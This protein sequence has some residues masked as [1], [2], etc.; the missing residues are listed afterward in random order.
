MRILILTQKVDKDD[1]T[2]GF[3]YR[4]IVEFSKDA[5]KVS[6]VCLEEGNHALPSNVS[7]YSLGKN[8]H[9]SRLSY[10]LN[11]YKYIWGLRNEYD[12]VFVHMNPEY[13]VM[14]GLIW[15]V[16]GK[17]VS[18]WYTHRQSNFKLWLAEKFVK[19]IFTASKE[20]FTLHSPKV[21]ILGHGIDISAYSC[22]TYTVK[23][24]GGQDTV[25]LLQVGRITPIKHCLE[26]VEASG[27]LRDIWAKRVVLRFVGAPNTES[28]KVYFDE[29]KKRVRD[30]KLDDQIQFVGNIPN[31]D[32]LGEYCCADATL[33]LTPTGG[34]DKVVLESMASN[35][36][37]FSS[38]QTFKDYFV[39]FDNQLLLKD[40]KPQTV[41]DAVMN[42][43]DNEDISKIS[44]VLRETATKK[45]SVE[46]L[47]R[48]IVSKL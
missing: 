11:F 1:S 7:V 20:S 36:I 10:V 8:K 45:A 16:L 33:N 34:L 2:L 26:A 32:I 18:L 25:K 47:I 44:E 46:V 3:F 35:R 38:N 6:V 41:A 22:P 13:V 30:L 37:V 31:K 21:H 40:N 39:P 48:N 28:D 9:K 4:W 27:I 43:F 15:K 23:H 17:K 42:V 14:G 24:I 5:E 29:L 19:N 12:V